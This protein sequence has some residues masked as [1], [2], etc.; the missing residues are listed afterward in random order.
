MN[1]ILRDAFLYAQ[2]L[3]IGPK[4]IISIVLLLLTGLLLWLLWTPQSTH[5]SHPAPPEVAKP[6]IVWD[7]HLGHS[8]SGTPGDIRTSAFQI[9]A[10]NNLGHELRLE[11]AYAIS[12]QGFGQKEVQIAAGP[13]WV[14]VDQTLPIGNGQSFVLRV[15]FDA[16]PAKEIYE[17][18]KTFQITLIYNGGSVSRQDVTEPMVRAVYE[19]FK[20]SPIGPA[21]RTK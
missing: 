2:G 8:Y 16:A 1:D 9:G 12:G 19:G 10:R 21:V 18:W 14:A 5:T 20:P 17:A 13:D 15:Q 3:S 6:S 7:D 11:Q 4:I